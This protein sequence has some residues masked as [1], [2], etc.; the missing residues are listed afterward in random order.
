MASILD[1]FCRFL[2]RAERSP[3]TVRVYRSDLEGLAK[4]FEDQ[5]GDPFSPRQNHSH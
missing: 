2:E 3:L 5:T 4:W 1:R